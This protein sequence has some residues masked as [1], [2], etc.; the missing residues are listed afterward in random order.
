MFP[1]YANEEEITNP[2]C[3]AYELKQT[4]EA[5]IRIPADFLSSFN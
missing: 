2:I 5:P 3:V 4:F 1:R